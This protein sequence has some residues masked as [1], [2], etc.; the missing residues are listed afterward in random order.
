MCARVWL[1]QW[2]HATPP[3]ATI[4][5]FVSLGQTICMYVRDPKIFQQRW[6]PNS[7]PLGHGWPIETHYSPTCY[8]TRVRCCRPIHFGVGTGSQKHLGTL[9]PWDRDVDYL[10]KRASSYLYCHA[11][12]SYSRSNCI[13][14]IMEICQKNLT[15]IMYLSRSL[16]VTGITYRMLLDL[17]TNADWPPW[18]LIS[19]P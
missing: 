3:S 4:P 5:N 19:H 17:V 18:L 9:G 13:R 7:R 14:V 8:C 15:L 2:I 10:Q 11:T 12:F 1:R 16:K 6:V